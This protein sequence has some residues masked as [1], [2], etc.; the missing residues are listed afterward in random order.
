MSKRKARAQR[1]YTEAGN[2]NVLYHYTCVEHLKAIVSSGYLKLTSSEILMPDGTI[3][4]ELRNKTFHPVVWLTDLASAENMGLVGSEYDKKAVRFTIRKRSYMKKW[5]EWEPQKEM[6]S[7]WKEA[8]VYNKNWESWHIS[9]QI[10]P[11]EDIL[12]VENILD[13]TVYFEQRNGAIKVFNFPM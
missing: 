5:S 8:F 7:K 1:N 10:I 2:S 6:K 13:G 9:E 3:E 12:K 4:T 11:F